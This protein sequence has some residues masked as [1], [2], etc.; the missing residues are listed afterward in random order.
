MKISVIAENTAMRYGI[1]GEHGLSLLVETPAGRVLFDAGQNLALPHNTREMGI[2]LAGI[3]AVV[4]S[5]GHYDHSGGLCFALEQ[6]PK[7]RLFLHPAAMAPKFR[8]HENSVRYIGMPQEAVAAALRG[9]TPVVPT[10]GPV[11]VIKG[12]FATGPVPRRNPLEDTGGK[13]FLDAELKQP[14]TIEDDQA[15]WV[16]N[17]AGPVVISGCA[18]SGI[19]NT[20]DYIMSLTGAGHV[21]ALLGGMHLGTASDER[22]AWTLDELRRFSPRRMA[23]MHCTGQ[24]AAAALWAAFPGICEP[25]GAGSIFEV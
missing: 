10:N 16:E 14:D 19:V 4:L 8:P 13:F 2:N 17:G 12:V 24:K 20:L 9:K 25:C 15:L 7:A 18:H 23:A 11:E 3:D 21:H 22:I 5:H 1:I 6:A